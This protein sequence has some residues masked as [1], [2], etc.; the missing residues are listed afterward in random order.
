MIITIGVEKGG[1][2]KSTMATNLAV[3]LKLKG[4]DIAIL[5]ADKQSTS[6]FWMSVRNEIE[7]VPSIP[8][9]SQTVSV[10]KIARNLAE[11]Y[12]DVIIDVGGTADLALGD[13]M[14]VSDKLYMPLRPS[15][16]DLWTLDKME[17]LI[18]V[19]K[20]FNKN[21]VAYAFFNQAPTHPFIQETKAAQEYLKDFININL[22]SVVVRERKPFRDALAEGLSVLEKSD[23]K[24]IHEI[25]SLCEEIFGGV[26]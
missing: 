24:S 11:K 14:L 21:L 18:G 7:N 1:T 6:S 10:D 2:G 20:S 9:F 22:S 25:T 15:Q 13:A 26:L 5:D 17:K 8:V 19:S 12:E 4:R 3:Y 16:A 23:K